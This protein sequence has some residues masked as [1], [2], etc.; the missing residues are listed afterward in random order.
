MKKKKAI[1]KIVKWTSL[2]T[3]LVVG[4]ICFLLSPFFNIKN[5]NVKG[6]EKINENEIISLSEIKLEENTFKVNQRETEKLIKQNAY[7][8]KVLI[9]RKLPNTIEI[10]VEERE[11]SYIL[12]FA[13]AYVYISSQGYL[14]EITNQQLNLPVITGY[15]T[16]EENIKVGNRL[17][18]E[19]LIKLEGLL[20]IMEAAN[21]NELSNLITQININDKNNY[22]LELES[23][24]K[25]VHVGD[26]SNLSTK[27][28][29]ILKIIEEE[30]ENKGEI[31]VNT[32]LN[33]KGAV[34]REKV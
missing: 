23:E 17:C 9:K 31:L 7:I 12:N 18:K 28:L 4:I 25:T 21:S 22:I 34:F 14:L 33:N 6:N 1:L 11:P 32:D 3:I 20:K 27:M 26:T 29:Y 16:S 15:E 10:T 13:N 5:I 30:K 19:D 8:D 24:K 2:F